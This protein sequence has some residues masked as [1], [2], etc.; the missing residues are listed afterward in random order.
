MSHGTLSMLQQYG[1]TQEYDMFGFS[2]AW[3]YYCTDK[4]VLQSVVGEG[5]ILGNPSISF[6]VL[7]SILY[8]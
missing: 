8:I 2:S 5:A 6:G 7:L 1:S 3:H 4:C